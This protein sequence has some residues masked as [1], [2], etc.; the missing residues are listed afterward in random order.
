MT[1]FFDKVK[2][3][4]GKGVTTVSVKLKGL[5]ETQ[6]LKAQIG[7]LLKQKS[8]SLG[9]L[10]N[11]VYVMFQEASFDEERIKAKCETIANLDTQIK[12]YEE[13]L[14]QIH[15]K[16]QEALGEPKTIAICD[17]GAE[18]LEGANFCSQ[19]GKKIG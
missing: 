4:I 19:C 1:D 2:Q 7:K 18:I 3:G 9:E 17:C 10:G 16:A 6:R 15:L 8:S 5:L 11:I 14:K 13:Q 12:E